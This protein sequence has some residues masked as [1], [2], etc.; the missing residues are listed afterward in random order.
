VRTANNAHRN[1]A[2]ASP[3]ASEMTP[4]PWW[5][6]YPAASM[7]TPTREHLL[8]GGPSSVSP[9]AG[10]A[11]TAPC[12]ASLASTP[13]EPLLAGWW[14][15]YPAASKATPTRKQLLVGGPFFCVTRRRGRRCCSLRHL[16]HPA[17][18]CLPG[19]GSPTPLP[20]RR[21]PSLR[22]TARGVGPLCV[23]RC[24]RIRVSIPVGYTQPTTRGRQNPYPYTRVR[25]FTGTGT[26]CPEKPQGSP[27]P[28]LMVLLVSNQSKT[29]FQRST[30]L[31]KY[32]LACT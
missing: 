5:I 28:S 30:L 2:N 12:A 17:S 7:T 22:A 16:G 8:V 23:S 25:V 27:C 26:G 31:Q 32:Y 6:P 24:D 4:T 18:N 14:I 15:R 10:G 3:T 13:R 20:P 29:G 11:A 21:H 9:G 19:G 1:A